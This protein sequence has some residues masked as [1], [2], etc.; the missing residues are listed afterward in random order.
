LRSTSAAMGVASSSISTREMIPQPVRRVLRP[1]AHAVRWVGGRFQARRLRGVLHA[2]S[3]SGTGIRLG[4]LSM[5]F[6]RGPAGRDDLVRGGAVKLRHLDEEFPHDVAGMNCLYAVSSVGHPQSATVLKHARR[7][8]IK[9][10]WNQNGVYTRSWFGDGFARAN[11]GMAALRAEADYVVYQSA[12]CEASAERFLGP[13]HGPSTILYNPVDLNAFR[14]R[15]FESQDLVLLALDA[16]AWRIYHLEAAIR[17]LAAI[18]RQRKRT[19][20]L[21]PG[22]N[23]LA[24]RR[25]AR[26]LFQIMDELGVRDHV[27]FLPSFTPREAPAILTGA[28]IVLHPV[29][30]DACP[31]FVTEVLACG[32][33]VAYSATGGVPE[34]VG[35]EAGVGVPGPL[36]WDRIHSPAPGDLANAVLKIADDLPVYRHAARARAEER[37]SVRAW[38]D[39]HRAIFDALLRNDATRFGSPE[40]GGRPT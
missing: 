7:R 18:V 39:A 12:F 25:Q 9:I 17:S 2:V 6:P 20:L 34:L 23:T 30:N 31:N 1:L 8:G 16:P 15:W 32:L 29:Y 3:P 27:T 11:G 24:D 28:Q 33:P 14:P 5:N 35:S 40:P 36:D 21:V 13:F 10:I 37:F 38:I 22:G 4:Y 19:R 26:R